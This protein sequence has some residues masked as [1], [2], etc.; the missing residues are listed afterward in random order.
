MSKA[1]YPIIHQPTPAFLATLEKQKDPQWVITQMRFK[2]I[3][4]AN[5]VALFSWGEQG[6]KFTMETELG[7]K[8]PTLH[9]IE[10]RVL[11]ALKPGG[12]L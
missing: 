5:W 12:T 6:K 2:Q 10:E 8:E 1:K 7:G 4:P 9:A 11:R 3:G